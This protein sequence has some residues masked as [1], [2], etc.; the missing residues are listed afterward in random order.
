[1]SNELPAVCDNTWSLWPMGR[2]VQG[3]QRYGPDKILTGSDASMNDH[4]VGLGMVV[5]A[6]IPDKAKRA[7]AELNMARLLLQAGVLP[8]SL[9]HWLT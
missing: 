8:P 4:A 5:Y 6:D 9:H 7:V 3:I 1:L 2:F